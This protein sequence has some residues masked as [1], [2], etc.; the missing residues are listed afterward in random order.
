MFNKLKKANNIFYVFVMLFFVSTISFGQNSDSKKDGL[1]PVKCTSKAQT[2][3]Y[4]L[5]SLP[6]TTDTIAVNKKEYLK[7]EFKVTNKNAQDPY[8]YG[9]RQLVRYKNKKEVQRIK[10]RD[11][12]DP[13]WSSMPFVRVRK[14]KY[15]ADLDD[16]G[17]L[18][19]AVFPFSPGSAI[20]GTVKIYS[21][22]DQIEYW[23]EGKYRFEQDTFVQL[24][25]M[26]CSKFNL[27]ECKKCK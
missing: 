12:G 5:G 8:Y 19:F 9:Y 20:W 13:Y 3:Y 1:I 17:Y 14:Q 22:K 10:L 24:E 7:I 4:K 2:T 27:E 21:L 11:E 6:C 26:K 16:D 15:L 25:C 23:G 18:E